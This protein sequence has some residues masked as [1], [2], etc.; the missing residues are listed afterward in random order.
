MGVP[1]EKRPNAHGHSLIGIAV[2]DR[3]LPLVPRDQ[4][5]HRRARRGILDRHDPMR[6]A[7]EAGE[8]VEAQRLAVDPKAALEVAGHA[9]RRQVP[10]GD[11]VAGGLDDRHAVEE[12]R[13]EVHPLLVGEQAVLHLGPAQ[14]IGSLRPP[15]RETP[16]FGGVADADEPEV[17]N[18]V[19]EARDLVVDD[20]V[21]RLLGLGLV[22][23]QRQIAALQ[24]GQDV[25]DPRKQHHVRIEIQHGPAIGQLQQVLQ[26]ER[27]DRG[28][29]LHDAVGEAPGPPVGDAELV[30]AENRI[31]GLVFRAQPLR[32]LVR[33]REMNDCLGVVLPDRAAK[34]PHLRQIIHRRAG[35][36]VQD[37]S[38]GIVSTM[39]ARPSYATG[40]SLAASSRWNATSVAS[41]AR[42]LTSPH[43]RALP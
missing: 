23:R 12:D 22:R 26:R 11:V 30:D 15:V 1:S 31:E 2:R 21:Q 18:A 24:R 8:M 5:L 41:A 19:L 10:G 34:H 13:G 3:D 42:A 25:V 29:Q 38:H 20:R 37:L 17:E 7:V 35:E 39:G 27:L 14:M 16:A 40:I 32:A 4:L 36:D 6:A 33:Q 43:S 28:G 9:A